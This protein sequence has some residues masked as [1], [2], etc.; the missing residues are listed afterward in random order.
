[1]QVWQRMEKTIRN[2]EAMSHHPAAIVRPTQIQHIQ[3]CVRWALKRQVGLTVLGGGHSGHCRWPN[4]VA[5][6]MSAFNKIQLLAA[7]GSD[8][9]RSNSS[10]LAIV[11]AGF[12]TTDVVSATMQRGLTVPLGSHHRLGAGTWLQG[13]MGHLGLGVGDC[14]LGN[15]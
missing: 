4:I 8:R 9:P 12:T 7:G 11:G 15:R 1:M 5:V 3:Q 10:P 6:D 14:R 13:G 2:R